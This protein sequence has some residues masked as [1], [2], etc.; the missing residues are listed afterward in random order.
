MLIRRALP[1]PDLAV[2]LEIDPETSLRRKPGDQ[3]D[4]VLVEMVDLYAE[5][6]DRLALVRIDARQPIGEVV[7]QLHAAVDG[8]QAR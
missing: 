5:L 7:R 8:L 2:L 4:R 3:A 1:R 6:A